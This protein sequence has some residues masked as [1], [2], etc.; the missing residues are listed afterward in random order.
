MLAIIVIFNKK[1]FCFSS[2]LNTKDFIIV[3]DNKCLY[4]WGEFEGDN[5]TRNDSDIMYTNVL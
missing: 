3:H 5:T 4:I 1:F 2:T